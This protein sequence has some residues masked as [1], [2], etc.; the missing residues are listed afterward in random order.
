MNEGA[1]AAPGAPVSG[2]FETYLRELQ[3]RLVA[4][5]EALESAGDGVGAARF[6][7]DA[8]QKPSPGAQAGD[9][10]SAAPAQ[11]RTSPL[12]G[13]GLTCVI[14]G[15]RVFERGGVA[16]SKVSGPALPAAATAARPHLAGSP[17]SAMG[18]SLVLH[19][20][21]PYCPTAH[22]N[23]RA[24]SVTPAAG[25]PLW[26]FGGGCDLTPYYPFEDDIRHFHGTLK[27]ALAPF[28]DDVY[29]RLKQDCD[30]YFT[31]PHRKEPRG[32]GGVFFDDLDAGGFERCC[33]LTRAVGDAFIPAYL[34][35]LERR[36]ATPYGERERDFQAYRRGRYVEF[37]LIWDRGT[38][39]GLHG[40]GRTESILMSMPPVVRWRYDWQPE[41]GSPE[42]K[43]YE[44]LPPRD[45]V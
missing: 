43:I 27:T 18:V 5:C 32:V 14:E 17:F 20:E 8:W 1:A 26:W 24:L 16:F 37:N 34:P 38:L 21:N 23:V 29:R 40:D 30:A 44:L 36:Q 4:A 11:A 12:S 13:E 31:L 3:A 45:W 39:F 6:R 10:A 2:V 22:L 33:A 9:A 28:G 42:A 41:P 19:P 7:H 35:L 15:G 25:E